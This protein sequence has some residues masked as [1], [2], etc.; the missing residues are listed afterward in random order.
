MKK[1]YVFYLSDEYFKST[2]KRFEE[3]VKE[4]ALRK[5]DYGFWRKIKTWLQDTDVAIQQNDPVRVA[6]VYYIE[7]ASVITLGMEDE[8]VKYSF[9]LDAGGFGKYLYG[10]LNVSAREARDDYT[11]YYTNYPR[12]VRETAWRIDKEGIDVLKP[13][14]PES[15]VATRTIDANNSIKLTAD[16]SDSITVTATSGVDDLTLSLEDF[17]TTLSTTAEIIKVFNDTTSGYIDTYKSTEYPPPGYN[18][19]YW[20]ANKY[21]VSNAPHIVSNIPKSEYEICFKNT[22]DMTINDKENKEMNKAFKFDFGKITD[23]QVRM[24]MY[25]LAVKNVSGAWTAYDKAAG[26]LMDV[27]ILNFDASNMLY[28]MPVAMKDVKVGDVIIHARKPMFVVDKT[29]AGDLVAVDPVAGEKKTIMPSKSP[30]G[31]NF[32]TKVISLF[33]G[34]TS[35]AEASAENP[36]GNMWMLMLM[37]GDN[38]KDMLL[39]LMMMNQD[40]LGNMNPMMLALMMSDSGDLKDLALPLMLMSN[41]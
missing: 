9:A 41:K 7:G 38:N 16:A 37:G 8:G 2:I 3:L 33:D 21:T 40:G 24:S 4:G 31:F 19:T 20:D 1:T 5:M 34:I 12:S 13:V 6:T 11:S 22:D 39:P 26:D 30:F 27:D 35:N 10:R 15:V 29:E 14:I 28:K 25:G 32:C 18:T 36:F 17:K 23:G